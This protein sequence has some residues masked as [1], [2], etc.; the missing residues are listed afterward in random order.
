VSYET[1]DF[2]IQDGV[3]RITLNRP[4]AFN[5]MSKEMACELMHVSIR[6]G[7]EAE[8][9]AVLITGTGKAFCAGGD[10][11]QFSGIKE[12]LAAHLKEMTTY[13]HAA[14][15]RFAW[16]DA[17]LIAAVNGVAAGA[18][19]SLAAAC[20][21]VIAAKSA[22][23]TMAYTKA[24]LTPDGS[25]TWYLPRVIGLRRTM[26]LALTNRVLSAEEAVEW[27]IANRV[28]DDADCLGEAMAL[29]AELAKGPTH[30][31]GG[32]KKML[33]MSLSDSLEGQLERETRFIA[34]MANGHDAPEGIAAFCEKRAPDF[35]GR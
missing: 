20:D 29:A 12:G 19:M 16:M 9:R 28:V 33:A 15:S 8:I 13:L 34:E 17:P 31:F 35:V 18:G 5:A 6:C 1:F 10:L 30:A 27:G 22:R 26:E 21:L 23:F 4:D 24:G 7:E 14:M 2:E 11:T 32:V 3:A 25:S